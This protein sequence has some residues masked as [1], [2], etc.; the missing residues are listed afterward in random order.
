MQYVELG[1]SGLKVSRLCLGTMNFGVG[2]NEKD[3]FAI[4]DRALE[5]GI[6]FFDTADRYGEP[7]GHGMTEEIIGRWLAQGDRRDRI[8]LATKLY[9]AMGPGPNEIGLAAYHIRRA[10]EAS[11]K[12]LRTDHIDLYQMHHID[13]GEIQPQFLER[14]DK[15]M[16]FY[17]PPHLNPGTPWEE[18]YQAFEALVMQDKISYV[19][20]SNFAAWNIAQACEIAR[21][22]NFMGLVSEQSTYSLVKRTI[23]LEMVPACRAYGVGILCYSPLGGGQLAGAVEKAESGRRKQLK[24][25]ET[26]TAKLKRY[27]ELCRKLGE[28]PAVVALAWLL[29]NPVVTSP[30]LG[31][32][33]MD[34]L[35]SALRALD[36]DLPEEVVQQLEALFPGPGG[37]APKAYA[38]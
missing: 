14:L 27:E 37:E 19:G 10:C 3:S 32:R 36:L 12:R 18:I 28:Q 20:S 33:T 22:R 30:I 23:E 31:P 21:A 29:R 6:N 11:L 1:R 17:R 25:D 5:L 2:T 16:S 7:K 8:V 34:Q 15:N 26:Q 24:L 38:W 13:Y 9:G 4:M 35:E